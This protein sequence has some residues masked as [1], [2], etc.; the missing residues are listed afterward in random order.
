MEPSSRGRP[1]PHPIVRINYRVR[2][3]GM[4]PLMPVFYLVFQAQGRDSPAVVTCLLVWGLVWPQLARWLAR[5]SHDTKQAEQRNLL[6]DTAFVGA[7]VAS[8]HFSLWPSVMVMTGINLAVIAVGGVR[9]LL[10]GYVGFASGLAAGAWASG[11]VVALDTPF[12]PTV[13]SVIGIF[14]T[15]SVW[16]F[17][18]YEQ[19]RRF[20]HN[21]ALLKDQ[22]RQIEEKSAQL[23]LAKEQA[24]SANRAKSLFLANM[25]HELRTPLNAIIGY[26]ELLLEDASAA[27]DKATSSDL[28]K[29]IGAGKHLLGLINDVL[30]LSKIEAGKMTL[31]WEDVALSPLLDQ[32]MSSMQTLAD[33]K[34]N[35]LVLKAEAPGTLRTDATRLRQMLFNL[36]GNAAKFTEKGEIE[37]RLWRDTQE[38][39]EWVVLEVADTGIGMSPEHQARLFQA[40]TQADESTTRQFG[41]TGLGLALTR[42]IASLLG[43]EVSLRSALGQ[44]TTFTVRLPVPSAP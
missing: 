14:V 8:M 24:D 5:R 17:Q 25:S 9:L 43:G 26:S 4:A 18:T 27:G 1:A 16:A 15:T 39:R 44:G 37:L 19:S 23:E 12:W 38:A 32:V 21:R 28:K 20:V 13:A 30:D 2:L 42:H 6:V 7:W 36:L 10:R 34:G 11:F 29:I 41:G 31:L 33:Q 3:A 22:N 35:R 40:F